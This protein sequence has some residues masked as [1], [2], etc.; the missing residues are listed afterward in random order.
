MRVTT[1][2][3][4][5]LI[6]N[7]HKFVANARIPSGAD[8][9]FG[10]PQRRWMEATWRAY[11]REGRDPQ[12]LWREFHERVRAASPSARRNTLAT[13]AIPMLEQF[14]TWEQDET[15]VPADCLPPPR[16]VLWEDHILA[17]QRHLVYLTQGGYC[18]RQLCTDRLLYLDHVDADLMAVA[19]LIC[20]D[21]D[22]GAGRMEFVEV[23]HLR[24]GDRQFW[25]RDE[26]L[27]EASRLKRRLDDVAT[28]LM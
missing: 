10:N 23:W 15:N 19:V 6:V 16:N 20:A 26:L 24:E 11:F 13:N 7:P 21:A 2:Q 25:N 12:V 3:L 5:L 8:T 18:L 28:E 14:L 27:A 22:L 9:T 17:I 4:R 1:S